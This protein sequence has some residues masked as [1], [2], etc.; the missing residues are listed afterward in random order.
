MDCVLSPGRILDD[1]YLVGDLLGEGGMATV[2]LA[3]DLRL[4]REVAIKVVHP[5]HAQQDE[6]VARFLSEAESMAQL[7][8]SNVIAVYDVGMVDG[9]PYLVMPYHRGHHLREWC[10]R[11]GGPPV[12]VDVAIG[13]IT[14]LCAGLMA[15]HGV[16]LVHRDVKPD[17]I[18]VSDAFEVVLADLG[19]AHH[20]DDDR[21]LEVLGG[22]P[23]FL[24]PELF[25]DELGRP[26]L[27]TKADVYALGVTAYWLLTGTRPKGTYLEDCPSPATTPPSEL[28]PELPPAFDAPILAALRSDPEQRIDAAEL[29]RRLLDCRGSLPEAQRSHTPFVVV[30]DD[31]PLALIFAEEIVRAVSPSAE[32]AALRDPRAALS[33][34][35]SRAPDLVITDLDMPHVNGMEI[36]AALS[37]STRTRGTPIIV[38]SG[39]GGAAEWQVLRRLGAVQFFVKPLDPETLYDAVSRVMARRGSTPV[40][41]PVRRH[42]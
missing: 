1:K 22:T 15:M 34:I 31:D 12:E 4:K 5:E 26:E 37:G 19:L 3:R 23:G 13:V 11:R 7:R 36:V 16:G 17:N 9:C 25:D 42:A 33:I 18:L 35:E 38:C 14:Q 21:R 6:L 2:F 29:R 41:A 24:A 40:G 32:I 8:H 27:A 39:V 20:A 30:V 10:R 28:R